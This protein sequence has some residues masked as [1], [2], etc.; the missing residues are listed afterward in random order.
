MAAQI[1]V[2]DLKHVFE[3]AR[4]LGFSQ[5]QDCRLPR[6][7]ETTGQPGQGRNRRQTGVPIFTLTPVGSNLPV[8]WPTLKTMTLSAS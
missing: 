4:D 6:H 3:Q 7:R 8:S 1:V 2:T 5:C